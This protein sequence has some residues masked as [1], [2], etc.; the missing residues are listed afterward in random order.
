MALQIGTLKIKGFRGYLTERLLDF[1]CPVVLLLGENHLGKSSTLNAVEWCLFGDECQGKDTG[2]RERVN[3]EIPNRNMPVPEVSVEMTLLSPEGTYLIRRS[4]KARQKRA[5]MLE[6]LEVATPDGKKFA[7]EDAKSKLME[8]TRSSFKDFSTTIYQHQEVI[9]SVLTQEPKDRNQAIDRLLGL[10]DYRDLIAGI[11][12][13][14]VQAWHK[15]VISNFGALRN[16][17]TQAQELRRRDLETKQKEVLGAGISEADLSSSGVLGLAKRSLQSLTDF[18]NTAGLAMTQIAELNDW[19]QFA[20]F[21]TS[22]KREIERLRAEVPEAK[23]QT[24]LVSRKNLLQN[25]VGSWVAAKKASDESIRLLK[26]FQAKNGD[27]AAITAR[28]KEQRD[29]ITKANDDLR[30]VNDRA[31]LVE[32]GLRS[33]RKAA[34]AGGDG[35]CPLCGNSAP[36]L[37]KHLEDEWESRI[38]AQAID[39]EKTSKAASHEEERALED[40]D[41]LKRLL[42]QSYKATF[43][44]DKAR[45]DVSAKIGKTLSEED[46]P[47]A[48]VVALT[49]E[50]DRKLTDLKESLVQKQAKLSAVQA[51]LDK[52]RA[53]VEYLALDEKRKTLEQIQTSPEYKQMEVLRDRAAEWVGDVEGVKEAIRSASNDQ[54]KLRIKAAGDAIDDFFRKL[55]VHPVLNRVELKVTPDARTGLN[56][57]ELVGP[58][59]KDLGPVLSQGDL[60][61]LALSIFLG[62]AT[63]A[64]DARGFS[65]IMLDDP[66]Q[67]LGTQHKQRLVD[68]LNEV[69]GKKDAVVISTMD[70]ELSELLRSRITKAKATYR[71]IQWDAAN[72][73][74]FEKI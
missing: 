1:D 65:F 11:D 38:R 66:S 40:S 20:S 52:V 3:W 8:I 45:N 26:D 7:G 5:A 44:T 21:Q 36:D 46:D 71:F 35:R 55:A 39:F 22:L 19:S 50:I 47:L 34:T 14:G 58:D 37:L 72:G 27:E 33:L 56:S 67:S 12:S 73:P 10:S 23:E 59:D 16:E 13:A 43:E 54:A 4:L 57:Y 24:S 2:I 15:Q 9:R 32:E 68:V 53:I 48:I 69:S 17:I 70:A 18:A 28:L 64:V 25:S 41:S 61:S 31:K 42:N 63:S 62:L 60:N 74:A 29:I 30:Q 49:A 51:E 6:E